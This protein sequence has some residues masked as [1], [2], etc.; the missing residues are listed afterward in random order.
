MP[1]E[2]LP[3]EVISRVNGLKVMGQLCICPCDC[4]TF[5]IYMIGTHQHIQCT[6]CDASYCDGKC[7]ET[8]S[9]GQKSITN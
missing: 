5:I 6:A 8:P 7:K 9:D 4:D 3:I 1:L 2:L